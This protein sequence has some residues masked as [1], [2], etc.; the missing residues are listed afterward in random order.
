MIDHIGV[1]V[2]DFG[3]AVAFY[4]AALA[5]V[6]YSVLM[7]FPGT[8]GLG[9]PGKPDLWLMQAE[10]PP[11]PTHVAVSSRTREAIDA[12]YAAALAAG[13]T[14]NGP[15]GLRHDYHPTYYAAFV[16]AP[17]GNNVEVVCHFPPGMPTPPA[18]R[19]AKARRRAVKAKPKTRSA[20]KKKPARK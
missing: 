17:E 10:V 6:G 8:A 11:A 19:R 13:G 4:K 3:R 9:E 20:A 16:R 7:E 12:F 1:R 2:H 5:P 15:P 18:A 14:D